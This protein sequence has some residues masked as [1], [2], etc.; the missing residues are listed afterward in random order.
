MGPVLTHD[1][2]I[3]TRFTDEFALPPE[4]KCEPVIS[5]FDRL[6]KSAIRSYQTNL[7]P[8]KGFRC[9]YSVYFDEVSCS[10]FFLNEINHSAGS[11]P[12]PKASLRP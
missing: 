11:R 5:V 4:S 9:A 2:Q 10:Q 6:V 3:G 12:Q 8:L 7:S 1:A